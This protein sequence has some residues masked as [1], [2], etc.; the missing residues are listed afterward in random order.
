MVPP[1]GLGYLAS[2]L[3]P[4][5]YDVFYYDAVKMQESEVTSFINFVNEVKPDVVGIQLYSVDLMIVKEYLCGIKELNPKMITLVG[6]PHPSSDR[7]GTMKYYGPKILDYAISGEAEESLP[8]LISYISGAN[9]KSNNNDLLSSIDGLIWWSYDLKI[10][11]NTETIATKYDDSDLYIYKNKNALVSDIDGLPWPDW[12]LL[13]INSYP[14]APLGGFAKN[15]PVAPIIVSRG[16]PLK[17][18]F[19]S[20]KK[21]YGGGFR[22]RKVDDVIDEIKYL[23]NEHGAREIM[24]QDDNITYYRPKL[25]EFC[26]QI[27]DV[28]IPWNCLNGIRLDSVNDKVASS[29]SLSGCYA[30]AVG[31]ESGSQRVLDHMKKKIKVEKIEEKINILSRHHIDVTGLFIIGYPTE[32]E[33]DV[34]KTIELSK[35]LKI[36]QAAFASFIPLPGTEIYYSLMSDGVINDSDYKEMSYYK[37]TK[38]FS[39]SI[40]TKRMKELL[41]R[42]FW[43]FYMRPSI[44]YSALKRVGSFK[45]LFN[46]I[47]RFINVAIKGA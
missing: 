22:F 34:I 8:K 1:L 4:H 10:Y 33:E 21:I 43:E 42:S 38:S 27:K 7:V 5:G 15:F 19:C 14:D 44:L 20:A 24:I 30:V 13:D 36:T 32:T 17:C 25:L 28:N 9:G 2:S 41:K 47:V 40:S 6:G 31:I 45:N 12:D 37:V 35:K 29:M 46:L 18:T 23:K 3:K 39:P 16:C 11:P 26:S